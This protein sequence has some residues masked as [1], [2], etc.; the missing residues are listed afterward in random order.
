MKKF[1]KT[2]SLLLAVMLALSLLAG[3]PFAAQA[4]DPPTISILEV[5]EVTSCSLTI[6]YKADQ[7]GNVFYTILPA[8]DPAPTVQEIGNYLWYSTVD[9]TSTYLKTLTYIKKSSITARDF[10]PDTSYILYMVAKT[11]AGTWGK[12]VYSVPFTTLSP[13]LPDLSSAYFNNISTTS[14]GL[15]LPSTDAFTAYYKLQKPSEPAP[16]AGELLDDG[17]SASVTSNKILSFNNLD[18]GEEYVVY[19][20]G[21]NAAGTS[22]VYSFAA[23][24]LDLPTPYPLADTFELHSKPDSNYTIYLDFDGHVTAGTYWNDYY[25]GGLPITTPAYDLNS[26]P[27]DFSKTERLYIQYIFERVAE[28]YAPFDV[29]VTTEE[30]DIERLKKTN[31]A[32]TEYGVRVAIGGDCTDWYGNMVG[33]VAFRNSFT[34][35][36]DAPCFVFS[37]RLTNV[38]KYVAEACSHEV[39]HTL[40][41][42][43]DG[44]TDGT[45]YWAGTNG[46]SAIMGSSYTQALT[47][48][49]KGEYADANN[50][51]DDLAIIASKIPYNTDDYGD[52]PLDATALPLAGGTTNGLISTTDDVDVFSFTIKGNGSLTLNLTDPYMA[53]DATNL[54]AKVT[55]SSTALAAD[56]VLDDQS[57]LGASY[58]G[59]LAAGTYFIA[60]EGTGK[61]GV[62]SD[63]GSL[64][65]Y[66]LTTAISDDY[67]PTAS[68]DVLD[69]AENGALFSVSS[70]ELAGNLY[71]KLVASGAAAPTAEE[72][73][74]LEP[75]AIANGA[76]EVAITGLVAETD[77]VIYYLISDDSYNFYSAVVSAAFTTLAHVHSYGAWVVDTAATC[78]TQ[79][80]RHRDC[81]VG[82]DTQVE[83]IPLD[84]TAHA[85]DSGVVTLEPTETE[86]GVK[87]YTCLHDGSHSYTE[88]I[89]P[90]GTNTDDTDNS[91]DDT[92]NSGSS[93]GSSICDWWSKI[94]QWILR[95]IFFGWIWM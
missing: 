22:E 75:V 35:P 15:Y 18:F 88:E 76:A 47:Q 29:D 23:T 46:Y 11:T 60:V 84:P 52:N 3:L 33:G 50:Q 51:E 79:G 62:Y 8:E 93:T 72:L 44:K 49:S 36:I 92:D 80:S 64:G 12:V 24:T 94:W 9:G 91:G 26:N 48:W 45:E 14:F 70:N 59:T 61:E 69:L 95:W 67:K 58:S 4:A 77:Y 27:S 55:I 6:S 42:T 82:D 34:Y 40:G 86:P 30:P 71:Y 38:E 56:I 17:T 66:V 2:T 85:W 16:T 28:D 1:K 19:V 20:V 63:Y 53:A 74:Q 90:L 25:T 41:L 21:Q 81:T 10:T 37:V 68:A 78:A 87:T 57:S 54:D 13:N 65:R 7:A 83:A 73:K 43:H 32:D 31:E 5:I 39:G 89:P